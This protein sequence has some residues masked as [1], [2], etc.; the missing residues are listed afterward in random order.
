MMSVQL[1]SCK[2]E[3]S[4]WQ[5]DD[6]NHSHVSSSTRKKVFN[7]LDQISHCCMKIKSRRWNILHLVL[8]SDLSWK[9]IKIGI[10]VFQVTDVVELTGSETES[11]ASAGWL[12]FSIVAAAGLRG[13]TA[14]DKTYR[15]M[16]Y[17]EA[18]FP[19]NVAHHVTSVL[20]LITWTHWHKCIA[21][22]THSSHIQF[23]F[24]HDQPK[25]W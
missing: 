2:Q 15:R 8:K 23:C 10:F 4:I 25:S 18:H 24:M 12:H 5:E 17:K 19:A 21:K 16:I 13:D 7:S 11:C 1:S 20:W 22:H 3:M 9:Q 6:K 14:G